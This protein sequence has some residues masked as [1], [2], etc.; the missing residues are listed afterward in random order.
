MDVLGSVWVGLEGV[1]FGGDIY[2][3]RGRSLGG[4]KAISP[5]ESRLGPQADTEMEKGRN[6][7]IILSGAGA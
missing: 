1:K 7:I 3:L 4:D 6:K 2:T 5:V